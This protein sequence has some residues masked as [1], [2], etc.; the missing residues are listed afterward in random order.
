ML[1]EFM[2]LNK[3]DAGI[4]TKLIVVIVHTTVTGL[5]PE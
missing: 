1:Q 5:Y 3:I 2:P 4:G